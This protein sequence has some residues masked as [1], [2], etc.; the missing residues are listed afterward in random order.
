L[1]YE[2]DITVNTGFEVNNIKFNAVNSD[3][4]PYQSVVQLNDSTVYFT[5][6][7][8]EFA[9]I[10]GTKASKLNLYWGSNLKLTGDLT[11]IEKLELHSTTLEAGGK[12][13]LKDVVSLDNKNQIITNNMDLNLYPYFNMRFLRLC[14]GDNYLNITG[15]AT[16]KFICEFPTNIGG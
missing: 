15:D 1:T 7:T 13:T 5:H 2:G 11:G 6:S 10:T 16:V 8:A 4:T 14:R 9:S 3:G 12:L